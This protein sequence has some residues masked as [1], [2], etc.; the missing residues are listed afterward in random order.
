MK[1]IIFVFSLLISI[2]AVAQDNDSIT[3]FKK[4]V[5]EN[6][7]VDFLLSY[8]KQEGTHSPVGGGI[9][10]E[11]LTDIASNI[12]VAVP[13]NDDDVLTFD[14]GIST[15]TS[16][17]SSNINPFNSSKTS[18][19]AYSGASGK[20]TSTTVTSAPYGTPWLASSGASASDELASVSANYSHSSDSRNTLWN[21]DVSFS[22]EYDYTSVGFGGGFTKLFNEKNTEISLKANAYLDQWRPIYPTELHEYGTYGAN[23]QNQGYLSGVT[24]MDRYG[25][26]STNYLP[27]AFTEYTNSNRN[28]YSASI[29]FS[30]ILTKKIQMSL[31]MDVLKQEGLLGTPY[32]RVYF[33]DKANYYIGQSQYI[34]VYETPANIGVYQLADDKERLPNTRFKVPIGARLNLY[35]NQYVVARTYYR[36]YQD[37]WGVQA[38]TASIELPV[39]INSNFT[40]YPMY[41]YYAQTASDYFAP[42]EKHLS[43]EKY[44][45]S[46]YDL[47]KFDS[48]QYGLGFTYTD[49]FTSAK[50]FVLGLK[51]IDLRLNHYQ[52][53]D[54]LSANIAS[55]GFKFLAQ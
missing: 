34:P 35:I 4:R 45:T 12:V 53:S 17:S 54:G 1:K 36:Y 2:A 31:F 32:Q 3:T 18:T 14:V 16:A 33:A 8:Y 47:S 20:S 50:I 41:R 52:R 37:N 11:K 6:T 48:N 29:S 39:K 43:T 19:S 10:S 9:G 25:N 5:L 24:I 55:L 28:S 49:I 38:H 40:A 21:A 51:S 23:F 26:K 22:N 7:E 30:Q 42:Y 15:Y 27:S 13:L 46:D 44:Y